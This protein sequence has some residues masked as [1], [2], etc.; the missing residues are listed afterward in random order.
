MSVE[1]DFNHMTLAPLTQ[2]VGPNSRFASPA[3][4]MPLEDAQ[5]IVERSLARWSAGTA[6]QAVAWNETLLAAFPDQVTPEGYWHEASSHAWK[7][8]FVWGHDHDFGFG[9][10][11]SG[12]MGTR[13]I[14]I[15]S[16]AIALGMMPET[17]DGKSVL[18][19]GC[20]SGG[21]LLALAGLGAQVTALEEH[22]VAAA[23]A[24]RLCQT[25]ACPAEVI[26]Q[27][28]FKDNPDWKQKFDYIYCSGVIYHVTDPLLLLRILFAYLK[29]GG[30]LFIETKM[31]RNVPGM[32]GDESW[33]LYS[34]TLEKGW[35][36]ISPS[37]EALG[38]WMVDVGFP[39]ADTRIYVR[40]INRTVSRLSVASRKA[41][42]VA[43]PEPAGFS[44]PGSWLEGVV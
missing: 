25:I 4:V 23:A 18:D 3:L 13:H 28:C 41:A 22:P 30:T 42:A 27:S 24:A 7:Q 40:P 2:S 20:W 11:R 6:E 16:E 5:R 1:L 29:P 8:F 35:N 34:G 9:E 12:A 17:L 21:D 37:R 44:R 36:W 33:C 39:A 10:R 32:K 19:V 43:L 14:E 15:M 38:R 26:N 31:G